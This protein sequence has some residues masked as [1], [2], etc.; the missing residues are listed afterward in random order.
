MRQRYLVTYDIRDPKRLRRVFKLMKG[1]GTHLQ[2][3]VFRC[4][5]SEYALATM[6]AA[7]RQEI[8][9]TEDQVL[10]VDV[11]PSDGRGAM[12]FESLGRAYAEPD[13]EPRIV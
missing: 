7:L 11:G 10:I 5:L 13:R 12:V 6:R 4:D 1:Y 8:D 9:P 2:L 3:S